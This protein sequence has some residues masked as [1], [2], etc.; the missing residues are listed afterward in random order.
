MG[1]LNGRPDAI[2]LD[3]ELVPG[4]GGAGA[5]EWLYECN[6]C[7]C[8]CDSV[9]D[10]VFVWKYCCGRGAAGRDVE[11]ELVPV[12]GC[13]TGIPVLTASSYGGGASSSAELAVPLVFGL[14]SG[15]ICVLLQ[16][17]VWFRS[18]AV[19]LLLVTIT[20]AKPDFWN[21]LSL[22]KKK[23]KYKIKVP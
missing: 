2:E 14:I 15:K 23:K 9:C 11:L 8:V 22:K 6:E 19:L 16:N 5:G 17:V 4:R 20:I 12:D 3:P 1:Y 21:N 18:K 13:C 10:C 7:D